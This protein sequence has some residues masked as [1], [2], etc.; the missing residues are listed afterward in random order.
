M[1]GVLRTGG[2]NTAPQPGLAELDTLLDSARSGGVS[3]TVTRD[4]NPVPLPDGVDLSAYRIVQ[5]ALSNAMRHAPGSH[6]RV[7][8]AFRRDGLAL[9]IRN[10][11]LLDPVLVPSGDR[12]GGGGHGLV[13][14]RERAAMLGGSLEAGP[15]G[16]GEFQVTA[17]LP[18]SQPEDA[19]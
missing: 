5:E 7:H 6:V 14:M 3:V 9:E 12:A 13:G 16:D 11:A 10:D 18:V 17:F 15:A 2:P 4:G 19:P 1:L 8:M